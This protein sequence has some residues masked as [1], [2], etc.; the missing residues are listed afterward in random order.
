MKQTGFL[1]VNANAS[2]DYTINVILQADFDQ[3]ITNQDTLLLQL[4][5]ANAIW[6]EFIWGEANWGSFSV[7]ED[8]LKHFLRFKSLR[9][10]FLHR[11]AGQPFQINGYALSVQDKGLLTKRAA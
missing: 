2:G 9:I 5:A 1:W 10:G 6:N 4:A 11:Q 3:T 7:F 8:Q